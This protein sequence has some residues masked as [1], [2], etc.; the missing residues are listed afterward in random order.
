MA[1]ASACDALISASRSMVSSLGSGGGA[2]SY[3]PGSIDSMPWAP[4][5]AA[6]FDA[7]LSYQ[8][9]AS[10]AY[11]SSMGELQRR[12]QERQEEEVARLAKE[13]EEQ[14]IFQATAALVTLAFG[15]AAVMISGGLATPLVAAAFAMGA[16][17]QVSNLVEGVQNIHYGKNGDISSLAFNPLRDTVFLGNQ[18][19]YDCAEVVFTAAA[20][21][22]VPAAAAVGA[23]RAA[24]S[25]S[26]K[27]AAQGAKSFGLGLAKD[28]AVDF[29]LTVAIDTIVRRAMG[30]GLESRLAIEAIHQGSGLVGIGRKPPSADPPGSPG[31]PLRVEGLELPDR[32]F[33]GPCRPGT[34]S[35]TRVGEHVIADGSHMV[36]GKLKPGIEYRSG[37]HSYL[38]ATDDQGRIVRATADGLRLKT[39]D[40]RLRH[41]PDTPGKLPDDHAGH[42][43]GDRFGGSPEIDNLVSQARLVN[44]SEFR[45]LENLWAKSI[46]S[47]KTVTVE[48]NLEYDSPSSSRPS[49][50]DVTYSIDEDFSYIRIKN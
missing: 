12:M 36:G 18:Q 2:A 29:G 27:V 22:A 42:L 47:G 24:G 44:Q 45:K 46:E 34:G 1:G 3:V 38:Y 40:G 11:A 16:S 6:A 19:F 30:D 14:G 32:F 26:L 4:A 13:R 23:A 43:F 5:L 39:H 25:T 21:A 28:Q 31:N 7:S 37:E 9:G 50:F 49:S 8:E 35:G 10:Q 41:D 20:G 48:I 33:Q 15:V 17:F